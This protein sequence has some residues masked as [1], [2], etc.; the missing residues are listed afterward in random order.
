MRDLAVAVLPVLIAQIGEGVREALR[1]RRERERP[2][3]H[4]R[5]GGSVR[6]LRGGQGGV[7]ARMSTKRRA[8]YDQLRDT[9]EAAGWTP[10][11]YRR[12][13][14]MIRRYRLTG[15]PVGRDWGADVAVGRLAVGIGLWYLA[16]W[17]AE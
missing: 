1:D 7:M 12:A 4:G 11:D 17:I 2:C 9:I 10:Q 15:C 3:A 13:L 8:K 6:Q 5:P 16:R 14:K